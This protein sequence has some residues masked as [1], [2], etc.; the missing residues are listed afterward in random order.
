MGRIRALYRAP[1]D[2]LEEVTTGCA[3]KIV[4]NSSFTAGVFGTVF[5]GLGRVP[6]VIFP[7]VDVHAYDEVVETK[8]EDV[9]L[10]E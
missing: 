1:I 6:R 8:A 5:G 4:V 9:W 2:R 7:A 10:V 3:D